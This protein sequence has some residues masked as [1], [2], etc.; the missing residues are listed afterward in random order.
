MNQGEQAVETTTEW[1]PEILFE[2]LSA[3]VEAKLEEE[4][5][6]AQNL[7]MGRCPSIDMVSRG[8]NMFNGDSFGSRPRGAAWAFTYNEKKTFSEPFN[9]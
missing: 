9:W 4:F 3:D 7:A 6:M 1:E 2:D 8:V 5:D